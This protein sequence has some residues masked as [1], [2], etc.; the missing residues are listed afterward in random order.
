V[1][2]AVVFELGDGAPGVESLSVAFAMVVVYKGAEEIAEVITAE[3]DA[4]GDAV[5]EPGVSLDVSLVVAAGW[6]L[7]GAD[8]GADDDAAAED[9]VDG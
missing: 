9:E 3:F 2:L 5:E 6:L 7:A 1:E 8:E 4:G